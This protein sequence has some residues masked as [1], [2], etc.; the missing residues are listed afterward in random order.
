MPKSCG[1]KLAG[2]AA[3]GAAAGWFACGVAMGRVSTAVFGAA[4]AAVARIS[5]AIVGYT[6]AVGCA[7]AAGAVVSWGNMTL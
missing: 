6:R 3:C 5:G 1:L 7:C 4:C 2:S